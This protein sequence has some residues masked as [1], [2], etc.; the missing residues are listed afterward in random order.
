M[1]IRSLQLGFII[2]LAFI[3]SCSSVTGIDDFGNFR[4]QIS[5]ESLSDSTK[6]LFKRNAAVLAFRN[7]NKNNSSSLYLSEDL[8]SFYY[9]IQVHI[10]ASE[11]GREYPVTTTTWIFEHTNLHELIIDPSSNSSFLENWTD[12][13]ITTSISEIDQ[14]LKENEFYIKSIHNW[15]SN[16]DPTFVVRRN[17]PINTLRLSKLLENTGSFNYVEVNGYVGDG[18]DIII[19]R[20]NDSLEVT[21]TFA[22]GDCPSGCIAE[23][24]YTFKVLEDGTV[25]F[26]GKNINQ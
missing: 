15:S 8:Q 12:S 5:D 24:Y 26:E 22:Y 1:I 13:V 17:S 14:L 11:E 20:K 3:S 9:D 6:E 21:Y 23:D 10:A 2:F 7:Q 16:D 4:S 19:D 18:S 25:L